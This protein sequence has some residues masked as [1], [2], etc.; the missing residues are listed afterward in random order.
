MVLMRGTPAIGK[1][2][3]YYSI[4]SYQMKGEIG[5][6]TLSSVHAV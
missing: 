6:P 5:M 4:P 3:Y 1:V 2:T